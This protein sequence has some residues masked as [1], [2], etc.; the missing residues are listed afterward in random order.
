MR[1]HA[2]YIFIYMHINCQVHLSWFGMYGTHVKQGVTQ[3][4]PL[5]APMPVYVCAG[6]DAAQYAL[7]CQ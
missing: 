3:M 7:C 5:L 6:S 4:P 2:Q 1:G